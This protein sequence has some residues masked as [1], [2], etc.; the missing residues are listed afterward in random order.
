[1][2]S[3]FK[4]RSSSSGPVQTVLPIHTDIH[5]HILPGID[6]GSPDIETSLLLVKGLYDLGIRKTIATPHVIADMFRNT[7]TTINTA[8]AKLKTAVTAE[9]I[10]IEITAAAEYML[11]DYFLKLLRSEDKLLTIK[12]NIV[13]TEQSYA[14]PTGNLNEIAFELVTAG[15][16]P[17]MAHPERYAFYHGKYDEFIRL[18]DMGFMLQVNLL[19][20]TG[21]YGK[22]AAKAAK[23]I[24][25]NELA[26]LVGTDLHH[27]RHLSM[28]RHPAS[29]K[30]FNEYLG[31]RTFND[32][33]LL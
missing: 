20:L 10:D 1:M 14:T 13:L 9:G 22:G 28:L 18:K 29:L 11:D 33:S 12:D 31:Y 24:F 2:F 16:K 19:S 4:K 7:P 6:D 8:L 27:D 26:D 17:I 21:Y 15:Y 30:L 3:F 32:L 5:S 23:Y 25:D